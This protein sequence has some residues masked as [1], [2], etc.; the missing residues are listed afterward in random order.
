MLLKCIYFFFIVC[1]AKK[2]NH[3]QTVEV[4]KG[5]LKQGECCCKTLPQTNETL[6]VNYGLTSF[7]FKAHQGISE[8]VNKSPPG[9]R[10]YRALE[11]TPRLLKSLCFHLF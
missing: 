9:G 3:F 7:F 1:R 4:G 2:M 11:K 6:S 5:R 10:N 8:C